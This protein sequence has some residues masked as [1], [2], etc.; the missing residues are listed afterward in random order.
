MYEG[1]GQMY[2]WEPKY[3]L[4]PAGEERFIIDA[5]ARD[6]I[7]LERDGQRVT[8]LVLNPGPWAITAQR[9]KTPEKDPKVD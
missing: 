2:F 7:E 9:T 4:I 8:G 3:E 1:V 6:V 5:P